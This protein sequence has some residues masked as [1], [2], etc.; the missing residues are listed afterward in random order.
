[1]TPRLRHLVAR[2]ALAL[3]VVSCGRTAVAAGPI[4]EQGDH[5]AYIGNTLADR[6]QHDGWLETYLHALRPD[7][8][9][10]FRNLGFS[11]DEIN[12]RQRAANF[13]DA[14]QWLDK[15]DADVI[16]CFFGY[17][18]SFRGERGL[19]AFANELGK[20]IDGMRGRE[21]NG[22]SPPRLVMFSP[23]AHEDLNS[24][25]LPDGAANN[26]NLTLYT[27]AMRTV[28]EAKGVPF[29]D[30][31]AMSQTL[32]AQS[33]EP[34]TTNGVHLL[35]RGNR[36]LARAILTTPGSPLANPAAG[37]LPSDEQIAKL[38]AAVL[39]K[40]YHW[41]SRY[42]VV[43]EYNVF[44]GRS[45]LA[46]FGQS[47]GDVMMR[48]MEILDVMTANRDRK[49]WALAAGGDLEI[50]DDNLPA[51]LTVKPNREGPLEGGAFE[52]L[53][54]EEAL[55]EMTVQEGLEVNL[56]ASEE[57]FPRLINP[58]QMSVD[59]DGRLWASV[60]PSYPHW[61]PTEPRRD[62]LVILPDEDGDGQADDC[63]VF[64]DGLNSVTGFEFWG[65]GVLVAALPELWFLKDTDGDDKADVKI[66]LLQ[67]LSSADSHHSANAM[68]LGPDGWL[69]W[70]RGVFNV[71]AIETPAGVY[72]SGQ[73][74]V[75]RFN[76]RTFEMEFHYPIGPN[77]HGDVFDRW[78]YQFANDG[79]TGTGGYVS[80]GR[81]LRP[82]GRQWFKK[83][84]RPVA[85]TGI[86]SSS[87]FPEE[88]Q[89]NFLICNTI[90]FLG[91]LQYEVQY[92]G[93]EITA[94]R[95]DDLL[96]STD[97]NFRPVDVEVGGDGALYVA[98]WQNTLIGHM[99]H[100]IRDPN[101]DH[102]HGR[103]YRVTATGRAPLTP[104][105]MSD[106]STA[107]VLHNFFSPTNSVRY[108]ARIELTGRDADEAL[109]E[110]A[111]F[112]ANL[113]PKQ[114]APERDEAQALLEC[115]WVLEERRAPAM[116]LIEKTFRADEPRVRA[117]AVRTL[118]HWANHQIRGRAL[119]GHLP[120][121][122]PLLRAAATDDSALVRA[123]ALKAAVEFGGPPAAEAIFEVAVRPVD[124]ELKDILAYARGQIDVDAAV[125]AAIRAGTPLSPAARTYAL[126]NA[127]PS[128]LLKMEQ[129]PAV[130]DAL[131]I[132]A[133]VSREVRLRVLE[134][135][136][137]LN[138]RS[139][140]AELA[141][142]LKTAEKD[143]RNSLGDLAALLPEVAGDEATDRAL[144]QQIAGATGSSAV[145][146]AAYAAW[147]PAGDA[148]AVW[149]HAF[150]SRDRLRDLLTTLAVVTDPTVQ[151]RFTPLVRPLM[152][153][154]PDTLRSEADAQAATPGPP[155]AFEYFA[156]N[157]ANVRLETLDRL[158]PALTGRLDQF[159]TFVPG[160]AR[161]RFATKQIAS[162][163]V[164]KSGFYTFHL[165]S[166][167]GSRLYLDGREV[168]DH[169]GL[170]GRTQKSA[171][172]RLDAGLHPVVLTYFDNGGDDGLSLAWEGPG[173]KTR[174]ISTSDLRGSGGG[175]LRLQALQIV[176]DWPGDEGRKIDDLAALV[177]DDVLGGPA[178]SALALRTDGAVADR[179]PQATTAA[180][181][182]RLLERAE[183]ATPV[184]R[185]SADYSGRLR[186]GASL[187]AASGAPVGRQLNVLRAR[188]PVKAD[189]AV[190]ALGAEVYRRESHCATCH[191]PSG[192]GLPNLYPPI[193]GT[194][195]TN[196]SEDRLIRM[197]LD[198]MH[199]TIEVKGKRYSS[200]P[201]PPMTGFRHLLN[202]EEL[203][204]VLT[205]V[206]NSWSNRAKPIEPSR[207]AAL[208][209][210]D[211]GDDA[212]FWSAFDLLTEYPME[213]GS[214]PIPPVETD[215]WVPKLVKQWTADDF[216]DA[217]LAAGGRSLESG[218]LAFRRIGC[219]Q[220][221]QVGGKGGVFG[222]DLSRLPDEKRTAAH[223]LGSMLEPSKEIAQEY[224][225]RTLLTASGEVVSGFVVD[226]TEAEIRIKSDPLNPNAPT[227]V[228]KDEILEETTS[229][230]SAMPEGLLNYFTKEEALDLIAY[231]LAG[232][233]QQAGPDKN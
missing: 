147:L 58:V 11:G 76:P 104:V 102:E 13:G 15:V 146:Q 121:W 229:D 38:R 90:G 191:Q 114:A 68:L 211:R 143:G 16:L 106:Q 53:G 217:D 93:A 86:L 123:E 222:P 54:G 205:Y 91:L 48:E 45:K 101:R 203:A 172:V 209:A 127:E 133:G 189:P 103:I 210:I 124:P 39:D 35:D 192:Q 164:P 74:G 12:R 120:G 115:L 2:S 128:L 182:N 80:L 214:L 109:R 28:C 70:S 56:F 36:A 126:A 162:L 37:P 196:G 177:A 24:P 6:M 138:G 176:T 183:A 122:E 174:E 96:R 165:R 231:V 30:L 170:H 116:S 130:Y 207:V 59:P 47:N 73:S 79:T 131:L 226:E 17:N 179:L 111:A 26:A 181:L 66:R 88:M 135:S 225:M 21:Y 169:D 178:L 98:D 149:R 161:D 89:N 173:F 216:S 34:L 31:F 94:V 134:A 187:A 195:W 232:D 43:D 159:E 92:N 32:Y 137:K 117:A 50:K 20:L 132:R 77:P 100:N 87:H 61:N 25:H 158:T 200:P 213:D 113:D 81:G 40:N 49:I 57:Q 51:E 141:V 65:G 185:Q 129:S 83:E 69:Y 156:P 55:A 67:G 180:V 136:A 184:E 4:F 110:V 97:S 1:M 175:N 22:E 9:F 95:T 194:L 5:V 71:A 145:R 201:L 171:R 193:D 212:S 218:A 230:R 198:G 60:W 85:A 7:H 78:G 119:S 220:C 52:Y 125:A 46:W 223:V 228:P 144:L 219:I 63:V 23:I 221:H 199:G 157:P 112:T 41:F 197:A 44:G 151:R 10:T 152:F 167:D 155:V 75:H 190:M 153:K 148:D 168:I 206:R 105:A 154:L 42:R 202:D 84:W 8:Q 107:D 204:A 64:A 14:D 99:Q 140:F 150:G 227:V 3:V 163:L 166:D 19:E 142:L 82:G 188:I 33:E 224:A 139:S 118:G 160:G 233:A 186:L 29:V 72:R 18:E 27:D 208:R 215:G 62:A 108:R